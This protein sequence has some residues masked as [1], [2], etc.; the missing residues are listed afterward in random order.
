MHFTRAAAALLY[1]I[2]SHTKCEHR[3]LNVSDRPSK[4]IKALTSIKVLSSSF[5][6]FLA[7]FLWRGLLFLILPQGRNPSSA[8]VSAQ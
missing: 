3:A 8:S 1:L 2:M 5:C 6:T 4:M 7:A